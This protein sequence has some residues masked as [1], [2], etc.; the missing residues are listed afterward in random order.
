MS[1]AHPLCTASASKRLQ[2]Q[3]GGRVEWQRQ[4]QQ[5]QQLQLHQQQHQ[6]DAEKEETRAE[7]CYHIIIVVMLCSSINLIYFTR[8]MIYNA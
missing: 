8:D 6:L 2:P 1:L 5:Q 3:A 7:Q 4:M